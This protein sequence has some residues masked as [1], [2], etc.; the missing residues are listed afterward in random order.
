MGVVTSNDSVENDPPR[1]ELCHRVSAGPAK[2]P[3]PE[4]SVVAAFTA[5]G[6][7]MP[8]AAIRARAVVKVVAVLVILLIARNLLFAGCP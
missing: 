5:S 7:R 8:V 3:P 6:V 4:V 1:K 2:I